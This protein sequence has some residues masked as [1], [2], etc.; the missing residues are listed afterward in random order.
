[1]PPERL[2]AE[3]QRI[4]E[5]MKHDYTDLKARWREDDDY[6][7]WFKRPINNAH[8]NS[9]AAYYDLVPGF[10]QLLADNGGDLEKYYEA[11]EKL[12]KEPKNQRHA[13]LRRLAQTRI[14]IKAGT[15][16]SRQKTSTVHSPG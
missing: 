7:G 11:V 10:E 2:R 9:V 14:A 3:K 6:G 12:S 5:D 8:L 15:A 16:Q 1:M 13:A 4:F